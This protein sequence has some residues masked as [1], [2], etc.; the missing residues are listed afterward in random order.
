MQIETIPQQFLHSVETFDKPD[1]FR[2]KSGGR[3]V[4]VSHREA[5]ERVYHATLGLQALKLAKQDRVALLSE[6]RLEWA[7]ADL[8]ILSAGC[9]NVPVYATLPAPQVE[10]ILADSEAR[11]VFVSTPE[12]LA[13]VQSGRARL[14]QL[15][16]IISFDPECDV[17]GVVTFDALIAR[18]EMV[19]DKPAYK[20][21]IATIGKYDWASVLYTS[22]T[23]GVPKGSI[24]THWNFLSNVYSGLSVLTVE[25]T[26]SCLSFLPL[27]H[28]FERTVGY[29]VMLTAGVSIAYAETMETVA[30]NMLEI[31]PTIM[32]AVPRFYEK[33]YGRVM[34]AVEQGSGMKKSLFKWAMKTG[35]KYVAETLAGNVGFMTSRKR[36]LADTLVFRKLKARTGGSIRFFVSGGAPLNPEINRFFH[37][38]GI[39]ILEGYGLTETSPMI[40]ANTFDFL[41]FGTVGKPLPGVEV[42]I[43]EDGEI[44]VR[45]DLVMQGYYKKP[46]ETNEAIVDGWFHTGDIGNLDEDG[47]L[48]IT[49]RKKDIIVTAGGKNVAPQ[50]MENCIKNSR[51]IDE[52]IVIG[53]G[54]KFVSALIIPNFDN[55]RQFAVGRRIPH[56][57]D[58][59]LVGHP[60]V[61]ELYTD[62]IARSCE[63]FAGF[64]QI[65]KFTL[66]ETP[67]SIESG[68]LTPSL[69]VKRRIIERK[70]KDQIDSLYAD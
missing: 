25:P 38:A 23:T 36:G 33:I 54:R 27:S 50:P 14:P 52:A 64:E 13:K 7:L 32:C 26:D 6:N 39:P 62:E 53:N 49:D 51:F 63:A 29:Y 47:Y 40:S 46:D 28:V 45:G 2:Y 11:A 15:Q 43:A 17:D 57:S 41:R 60:Q 56:I 48:S 37:S 21:I 31:S 12:Q 9:I 20:D 66:L 16:H 55:L 24:L 1:A 30:D 18:G 65:K 19:V 5:L 58:E 68:E 42:K 8:A 22:G 61:V 34:T 67:L 44:L 3:Y 4:D 35:E 10:Y 59:E 69:K 70:Y